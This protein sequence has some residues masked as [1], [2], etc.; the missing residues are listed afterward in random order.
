MTITLDM[1]LNMKDKLKNA[2]P[3]D[4]NDIVFKRYCHQEEKKINLRDT[5]Q[6]TM[7][8]KLNDHR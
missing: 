1:L 7:G 2:E 6:K 3:S 5:L 8:I 4:P